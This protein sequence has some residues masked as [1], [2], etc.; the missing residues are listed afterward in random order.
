MDKIEVRHT[1]LIQ[2]FEICLA[3]NQI[4]STITFKYAQLSFFGFLNY[5]YEKH[6]SIALA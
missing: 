5:L 3:Y 6:F 2:L 4:C 1:E